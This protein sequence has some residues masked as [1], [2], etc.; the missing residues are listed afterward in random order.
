MPYRLQV[1][2]D[3]LSRGGL[4]GSPLA[5]PPESPLSHQRHIPWCLGQWLALQTEPS[6]TWATSALH[7]APRLWPTA[8][9]WTRSPAWVLTSHPPAVAGPGSQFLHRQSGAEGQPLVTVAQNH[10][11]SAAGQS[12]GRGGLPCAP[13]PHPAL[14]LSPLHTRAGPQTRNRSKVLP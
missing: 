4:A 14:S 3:F 8:R 7:Q 11:A 9:A 6:L 2:G 1:G 12:E 10:A 13:P 5:A